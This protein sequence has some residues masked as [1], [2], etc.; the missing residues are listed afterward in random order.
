MTSLTR[1]LRACLSSNFGGRMLT[2]NF[3]K[4]AS[5]S[6]NKMILSQ[7]NT[8]CLTLTGPQGDT[9]IPGGAEA[10]PQAEAA[11]LLG[12]FGWCGHR[13]HKD[14]GSEGEGSTNTARPVW[15]SGVRPNHDGGHADEMRGGGATLE[16][17]V[18]FCLRMGPCTWS[19]RNC[20]QYS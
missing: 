16:G 14:T 5:F 3:K 2:C 8:K 12:L 7:H 6:C 9:G 4:K 11:A 10:Q 18:S 20:A 17:H 19:T 15:C 1:V 13:E